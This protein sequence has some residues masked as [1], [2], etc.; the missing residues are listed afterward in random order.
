MDNL[1]NFEF[2]DVY[3]LLF[4]IIFIAVV[5]GILIYV[6]LMTRQIQLMNRVLRTQFSA[7]YSMSGFVLLLSVIG[8]LILSVLSLLAM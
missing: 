1:T 6:F 4:K 5:F 3:T 8:L 2:S 7:V